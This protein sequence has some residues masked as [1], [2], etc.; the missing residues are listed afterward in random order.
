MS[1]LIATPGNEGRLDGTVGLHTSA[2]RHPEGCRK[3]GGNAADHAPQYQRTVL[4]YC[5]L[6][7]R[8]CFLTLDT[9]K[10]PVA[11]TWKPAGSSCL[12][13]FVL[14]KKGKKHMYM[15]KVRDSVAGQSLLVCTNVVTALAGPPIFTHPHILCYMLNWLYRNHRSHKR[16]SRRVQCNQ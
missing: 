5:F 12:G 4:I 15:R 11:Q 3:R 2:T 10:P 6:L 9:R 1:C 13:L 7:F 16:G 8:I 14:E